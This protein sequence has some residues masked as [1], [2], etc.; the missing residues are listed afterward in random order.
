M[1][2]AQLDALFSH[3]TEGGT[4]PMTLR[5]KGRDLHVPAAGKRAKVARFTFEQLCGRP[6]GAEDYLGLASTFHTVLVDETPKLSWNSA[7][8]HRLT[9]FVLW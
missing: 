3:L 1:A 8:I 9:G 4:A 6:L 2:G 5:L 7:S